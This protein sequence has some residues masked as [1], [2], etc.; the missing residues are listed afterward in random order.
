MCALE[1]ARGT[2][3]LHDGWKVRAGVHIGPVMAG[4]VGRE[5]YQFD[6]WGDT[7]NVASRLTSAA[8]PGS[9]AMT[10]AVAAKLPG[11]D[12]V[13]RGAVE[14]KGKGAVPLVEVAAVHEPVATTA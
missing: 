14:L 10:E 9:V 8:S 11:L 1:I 13:A 5:R 3:E 4:I 12:V 6:I 2:S 7:V